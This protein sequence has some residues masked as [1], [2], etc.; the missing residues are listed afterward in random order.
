[1]ARIVFAGVEFDVLDGAV[2]NSEVVTDGQDVTPDA[3][4]PEAEQRADA[5]DDVGDQK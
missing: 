4:K 2:V 1:M 3:K 5:A